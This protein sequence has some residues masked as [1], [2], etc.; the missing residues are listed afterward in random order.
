V[1][2]ERRAEVVEGIQQLLG[3]E[4]R[5]R[6]ERDVAGIGVALGQDEAVAVGPERVIDA[7]AQGVEVQRHEQLGGRERAAH[8]PAAGGVQGAPR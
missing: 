7:V 8:V 4:P 3:N 1:H 2:A 6:Q 5:L